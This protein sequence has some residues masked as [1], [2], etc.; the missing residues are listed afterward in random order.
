MEETVLVRELVEP[1]PFSRSPESRASESEED[2]L[3]E[4]SAAWTWGY[5]ML[6]RQLQA[7]VAPQSTTRHRIHK[8]EA[9]SAVALCIVGGGPSSGA[10]RWTGVGRRK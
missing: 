3:A 2:M 9:R 5:A 4:V 10:L 7:K 8:A 6:T 1:M